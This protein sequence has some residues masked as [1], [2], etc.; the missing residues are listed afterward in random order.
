MVQRR[1]C[2]F[3]PRKDPPQIQPGQQQLKRHAKVFTRFHRRASELVFLG[4]IERHLLAVGDKELFRGPLIVPPHQPAT[5]KGD[6]PRLN[7]RPSS[8]GVSLSETRPAGFARRDS[9]TRI[10]ERRRPRWGQA[11][12]PATALTRQHKA[13]GLA[14]CQP[15]PLTRI[16]QYHPMSRMRSFGVRQLAAA[17]PPA[18]LLAGRESL[19]SVEIPASKLAGRKAA[20]SCRTPK[21]RH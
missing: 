12:A 2:H 13:P 18:S 3:H 14:H 16:S 19:F 11:I 10:A 4:N 15:S 8:Q 20:A 21:L 5:G 1:V 9:S 6:A 7:A 17:F